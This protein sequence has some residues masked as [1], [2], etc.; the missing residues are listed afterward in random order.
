MEGVKAVSNENNAEDANRNKGSKQP[1]LERLAQHDE[2]GQAQRR[3]SHH[4]AQ[5]CSEQCALANKRLG[6]RDRAENVCV[7]RHADERRE[8]DTEGIAA[9]EDRL[10]PSRGYPVVDD[11]AD[12]HTDEDIWKDLP[13]SGDH[14]ILG[15]DQPIPHGQVRGLDIDAAVDV[16]DEVLNLILHVQL[17]DQR[18]AQ[19]GD[20]ES[21]HDIGQSDLQPED[22]HEQY[23]AAEVDHRGGDQEGEGHAQGQARAGEAHEN[24]DGRAGTEGRYRAEQSPDDVRANPVKAAKNPFAPLRGEEALNIGNDK[25]QQAKQE[26]YLDHVIYKK[27]NAAADP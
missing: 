12:A 26:R 13:E 22:A 19:H 7:H 18:A 17:F 1:R 5:D 15:V 8:H 11:R 14:L 6:H 3:D 2:R 10:D 23:E 25:N 27:L 21:E 20:Y 16:A 9:A 4:E 24:R